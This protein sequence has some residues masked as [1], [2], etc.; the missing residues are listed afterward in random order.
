MDE[1]RLRQI[2]DEQISKYVNK[3]QFSS[4]K[5]PKHMHDGLDTV[6][7]NENDLIPANNYTAS[8]V[9]GN[10]GNEVFTISKIPNFS[11]MTFYGVATNGAYG[12][13]PY[14]EKALIT[15]EA[16]VGKLYE[17]NTVVGTDYY[18]NGVPVDVNY[19]QICTSTYTNT[20]TA[21]NQ[22]VNSSKLGFAY[23]RDGTNQVALAS[24]TK[25]TET[26]LEI[27]VTVSASWYIQGFLFMQ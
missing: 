16:R 15:G 4:I 6:K 3:D 13:G 12:G 2:V 22:F 25:I 26:S 7:I 18:S 5:I 10:A 21:A 27:T 1:I 14:A 8:L 19:Y 9:M 17:I 23:V 24:I 11:L 20:T